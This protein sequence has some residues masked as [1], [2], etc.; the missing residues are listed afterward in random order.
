MMIMILTSLSFLDRAHSWQFLESSS[1]Q[2]F[3]SLID[4]IIHLFVCMLIIQHPSSTRMKSAISYG[5]NLFINTVH[6]ACNAHKLQKQQL[7]RL[8]ILKEHFLE[9][10]LRVLGNPW[11]SPGAGHRAWPCISFSPGKGFHLCNETVVKTH[12]NWVHPLQSAQNLTKK[13]RN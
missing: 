3:L 1:E 12:S 8:T 13:R 11:S 9:E 5:E 7:D 10:G 2:Y 4:S 6:V